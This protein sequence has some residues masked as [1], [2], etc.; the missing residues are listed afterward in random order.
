V[1]QHHRD[2]LRLLGPVIAARNEEGAEN[3][4]RR[5]LFILLENFERSSEQNDFL[6]WLMDEAKGEEKEDWAIV[7]RMLVLNFG[8]IRTSSMVSLPVGVKT[9][10]HLWFRQ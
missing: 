5:V 8:A 7:A 4:V 1:A 9:W 6:S 2:G 3:P 10:T